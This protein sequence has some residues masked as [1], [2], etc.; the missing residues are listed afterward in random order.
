MF[1]NLIFI[2]TIIFSKM[3]SF[4]RYDFPRLFIPTLHPNIRL[5]C[6]KSVNQ[7]AEKKP[8]H[9]NLMRMKTFNR[10]FGWRVAS[11]RLSV[12]LK[13]PIGWMCR[14]LRIQNNELNDVTKSFKCKEHTKKHRSQQIC[15]LFHYCCCCCFCVCAESIRLN[16]A[17]HSH[18][19][20]FTRTHVHIRMYK[21]D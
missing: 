17:H 16:N 9:W 13:P 21:C 2:S 10:A 14:I 19:H 1:V 8:N 4:H 15:W 5:K 20:T 18:V 7:S 3:P 6:A 11:K 12:I